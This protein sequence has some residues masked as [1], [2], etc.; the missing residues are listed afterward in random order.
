M[1]KRV[2]IQPGERFGRLTIIHEV[3]KRNK[4]RYFL[5]ECDCGNTR[6]V[7]LVALRSGEI[8]SCGCL[9]NEQNRVA[10]LKHGGWGSRLYRI[11]HSMK[12][13]CLNPN[14]SSY[15][16]Y[17]ARGIEVWKDWLDFESFY[18][19]AVNNGYEDHLTLERKNVNGNYEP[20]NCEWIPQSEQLN[21]TRRSRLITYND[22]TQNLKQ[23]ADELGFTY[24]QLQKRL[25][26]GWTVERAFNTPIGSVS[27]D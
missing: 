4:K 3:E 8:K 20:S 21:N 19:W 16:H 27:H 5:C 17:G 2:N 26:S 14:D 13:R 23:W 6:E 15:I 25:D 1:G 11:W 7:R 18:Q 22:K 12:Q 9:R 10:N 24:K